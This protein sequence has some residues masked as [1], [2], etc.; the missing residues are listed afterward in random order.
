MS[1]YKR[2][3]DLDDQPA[4]EAFAAEMIDRFGPL[5]DEV[6]HLLEIVSIKV[7]CRRANIEKVDVGPKGAVISFRHSMFPNPAGLLRWLGERNTEARVRPDQSVVFMRDWGEVG[8]RLR[9][10]AGIVGVLA[11]LAGD[12]KKAAA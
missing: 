8:G 7:L 1:L 4:I 5:P 3:A 12:G 6:R 10:T 11:K 2:L 9:G